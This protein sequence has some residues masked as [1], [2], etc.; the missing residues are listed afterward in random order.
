MTTDEE[1]IKL[2]MWI[3][4]HTEATVKDLIKQFQRKQY[5]E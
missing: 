3:T 1:V 2:L 4:G 5:E